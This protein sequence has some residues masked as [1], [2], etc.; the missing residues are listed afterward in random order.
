MIN[1]VILQGNMTRDA[2]LK[3]TPKGTAVG[4]FSVALNHKW[5]DDSGQTREEV[6]FVDVVSWGVTAET[7]A[8]YF[9][10]GS[11]ILIEGRLKQET[12][13]DKTTG[14]NR[15]RL[16][17]VLEKFHFCGDTGVQNKPTPPPPPEDT[18][19]ASEIVKDKLKAEEVKSAAECA[20]DDVPY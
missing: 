1:K 7:V 11:P 13:K 5:R 6:S 8:K 9:Q 16:L 17:C 20:D 14:S 10:K 18:R 15:S 2:E 19:T 4:T 3:Y 12:W